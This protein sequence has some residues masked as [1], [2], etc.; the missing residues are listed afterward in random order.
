MGWGLCT[1]AGVAG[2]GETSRSSRA[3]W[4]T[5]AARLRLLVRRPQGP[6]RRAR[7]R[8]AHDGRRDRRRALHLAPHHAGRGEPRLRADGGPGRHPQR[9]RVR[10]T[11]SRCAATA[12]SSRPTRGSCCSCPTAR[13]ELIYIDPPWGTGAMRRHTRLAATRVQEGFHRLRR[14]TATRWRRSARWRTP[15]R[16]DDYVGAPSRPSSSGPASCSRQM[17]TTSTSTSTTARRTTSRSR[18]TRSSAASA[19]S[20]RSMAGVRLRRGSRRAAG[21]AKHDTILVATC[22]SRRATSSMPDA[23]EREPYMALGLVGAREGGARQA[24]HGHLV[25]HDRGRRTRERADWLPDAEA[26]RAWCAVDRQRRPRSQGGW[27]LDF[28]AGSG[29]AGRGLRG[30]RAPLRARRLQPGYIAV[31]VAGCRM[32]ERGAPGA[33]SRRSPRA[34]FISSKRFSQSLWRRFASPMNG[35]NAIAQRTAAALTQL[36][37]GR[38]E[39]GRSR[40]TERH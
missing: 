27:C 24:P 13:P 8:C 1:V 10:P 2:R 36:A 29:H 38:A 23:V 20:T 7:A 39:A 4:I 17:S 30:A 3:T 11:R 40:R 28:F 33:R 31:R 6:R 26:R 12:C 14:E 37:R 25:A 18:S 32:A 22:A 21:L 35:E 5:G 34:A 16:F 9:H 15:D 19:S